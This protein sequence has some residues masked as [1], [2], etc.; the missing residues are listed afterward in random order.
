[1]NR[2]SRLRAILLSLL[3]VFSLATFLVFFASLGP[4]GAQ[5]TKY[6]MTA[7]QTK[8][9][10]LDFLI[11]A[12]YWSV[13]KEFVSTIEMKNYHVSEPLTV[14]PILYPADGPEIILT[15]ITLNPSE[16]RLLNINDALASTGKHFTVG[17]AELKYNQL[18]EGVFGANLT[19]L[20]AP[21]SLIYNFQFRLPEMTSKL[22][23]LWWFYDKNTDGFIAV[24]NTSD[25]NVSVVPTIYGRQRPYRL[26]LV[27]LG[28]H[29]TKIIELRRELRKLQA[30]D[31]SA[32]GIT[33]EASQSGA[34]IAGG[35]L[36]S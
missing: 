11:A 20:N 29:K 13:E 16:T 34:V 14:T 26:D 6:S 27:Q 4:S 12:P 35:G 5:T 32:G 25:K 15:P 18:T 36:S 28:P 3:I 22:E 21:R 9:Q 17:A 19:V 8:V 33:L 31:V 23:G 24:Q 10:N 1:M 7:S 2:I 30:D